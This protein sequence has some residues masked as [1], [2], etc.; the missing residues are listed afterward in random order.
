MTTALSVLFGIGSV[1]A[2]LFEMQ[3]FGGPPDQGPRPLY[4]ASLTV[5]FALCVAGPFV[6]ARIFD[7]LAYRRRPRSA[8]ADS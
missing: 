4:L 7:R 1:L 6:V 2:A 3:G 8:Q 5:A